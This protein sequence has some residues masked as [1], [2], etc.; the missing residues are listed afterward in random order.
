M[1]GYKLL[2]FFLKEDNKIS[3]K[4]LNWYF[5]HSCSRFGS[6]G[7]CQALNEVALISKWAVISSAQC[8]LQTMQFGLY[9]G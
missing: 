7:V 2:D 8:F 9:I 3:S 1:G 4:L 5:Y 6:I